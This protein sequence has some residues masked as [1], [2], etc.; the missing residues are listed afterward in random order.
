MSTMSGSSDPAL[1]LLKS[2]GRVQGTSDWKPITVTI[3]VPEKASILTIAAVLRGAGKIWLDELS[4]KVVG[5]DQPV[6]YQMSNVNQMAEL[7]ASEARLQPINLGFED[8]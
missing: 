5:N 4:L 1:N 6:N 8:N 7:V 2:K 3:D